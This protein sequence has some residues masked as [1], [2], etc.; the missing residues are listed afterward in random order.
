MIFNPSNMILIATWFGNASEL[1]HL[2]RSQYQAACHN[3][4]QGDMPLGQEMPN[5]VY[6]SVSQGGNCG[7]IVSF[8]L[9]LLYNPMYTRYGQSRPVSEATGV[10]LKDG[11]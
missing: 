5:T 9:A 11:E 10:E 2:T 1:S 7:G 8:M 4:D 6:G 3:I